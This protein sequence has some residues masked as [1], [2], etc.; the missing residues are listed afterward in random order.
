MSKMCLATWHNISLTILAHLVAE[1]T[2]VLYVHLN[3]RGTPHACHL[4]AICSATTNHRDRVLSSAFENRRIFKT[5]EVSF[6]RWL[7]QVLNTPR[8]RLQPF[9]LAL[10][11]WSSVLAPSFALGERLV[12]GLSAT[13]TLVR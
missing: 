1:I 11:S 4:W 7:S 8:F 5:I 3:A 9:C 6:L 10:P 2:T 13:F 12:A